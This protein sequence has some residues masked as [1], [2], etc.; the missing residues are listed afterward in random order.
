M[1]IAGWFEGRAAAIEADKP[2]LLSCFQVAQTTRDVRYSS[3]RAR[4]ELGWAPEVG[5]DEGLIRT[6]GP[7]MPRD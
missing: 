5:L 1:P 6:F 4:E 7:R 2:P 3:R